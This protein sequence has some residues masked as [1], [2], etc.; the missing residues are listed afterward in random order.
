MMFI[1]ILLAVAIGTLMPVQAGI[2]AELT[3]FLNNPFMGALISFATGAIILTIFTLSKGLPLEE[4]KRVGSASPHLFLG[5]LLGALFVGSSIFF[6]PKMGATT[7]I[8]A[9]VTGQLLGSVLMD[10]FGLFNL[11]VI[12]IN[13]TRAIGIILL[14]SGLFLVVKKSA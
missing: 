9:Y 7:M 4:L 6:I 3:R 11:P 12:Q 13:F 2:N 8:A 10:H 1:L 5:G 14:F